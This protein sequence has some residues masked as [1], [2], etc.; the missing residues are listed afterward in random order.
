[1][2]QSASVSGRTTIRT[3]HARTDTGACDCGLDADLKKYVPDA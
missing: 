2:S 1:M 3:V